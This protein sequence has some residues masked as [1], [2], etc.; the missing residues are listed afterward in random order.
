MSSSDPNA[1]I[2]YHKLQE[3]LGELLDPN[4]SYQARSFTLIV[5]NQIYTHTERLFETVEQS[6]TLSRPKQIL[7]GK[8]AYY[9]EKTK[10]QGI[11]NEFIQFINFDLK[12][13]LSVIRDTYRQDFDLAS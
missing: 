4:F 7:L 13:S 6:A 1:L 10:E 8:M 9:I 5:L 11:C 2:H 3:S 12:L